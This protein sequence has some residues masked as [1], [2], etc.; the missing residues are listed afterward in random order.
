MRYGGYR[1]VLKSLS[2]VMVQIE[3]YVQSSHLDAHP[4]ALGLAYK[5]IVYWLQVQVNKSSYYL[6]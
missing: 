1:V 4:P 5:F 3:A 6:S 2:E